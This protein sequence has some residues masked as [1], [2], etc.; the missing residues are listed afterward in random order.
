M[1]AQVGGR[2]RAISWI[3]GVLCVG[4]IAALV[5]FTLPLVPVMAQFVGDGLRNMGQ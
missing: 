1:S 3:A 4:V 5:W 2:N